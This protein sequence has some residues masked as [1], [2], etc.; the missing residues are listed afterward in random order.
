MTIYLV[1]CALLLVLAT[2]RVTQVIVADKI[3]EPLRSW[4]LRRNGEEGWF[5]ALVHCSD[6][7][8]VWV[9]FAWATYGCWFLGFG[10]ELLAP[11]GF[12]LSYLT[13]LLNDLRGS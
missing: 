8:S 7:V 10:W 4:M 13:I 5:T 2:A 1:F 9:G 6:C 3:T 11:L 12:A